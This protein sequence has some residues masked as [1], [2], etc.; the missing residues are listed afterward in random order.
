MCIMF[1]FSTMYMRICCDMLVGIAACLFEDGNCTVLFTV[2]RRVLI[3]ANPLRWC[4]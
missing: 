4:V 1:M 2:E 3:M